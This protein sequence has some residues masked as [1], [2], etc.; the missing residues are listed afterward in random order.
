MVSVQVGLSACQELELAAVCLLCIQPDIF[1]LLNNVETSCKENIN[2][3]LTQWFEL[4]SEL[5]PVLVDDHVVM[6]Y[7]VWWE[8]Q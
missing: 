3:Q 8:R 5:Q 4:D 2:M 6:T 7:A 1:I